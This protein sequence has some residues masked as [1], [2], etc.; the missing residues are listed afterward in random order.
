M[1]EV[2]EEDGFPPVN[3]CIVID[4]V[5]F[6]LVRHG[7]FTN[8]ALLFKNLQGSIQS[9][10]YRHIVLYVHTSPPTAKEPCHPPS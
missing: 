10:P 3:L 9:F 4:P 7:M 2:L 5:L 6:D 1:P 8:T